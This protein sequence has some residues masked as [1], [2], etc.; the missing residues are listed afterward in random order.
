MKDNTILA[1]H[2]CLHGIAEELRFWT[3]VAD[4]GDFVGGRDV[5]EGGD[6]RVVRHWRRALGQYVT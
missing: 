2:L 3:E 5:E 4:D 6:R 1:I